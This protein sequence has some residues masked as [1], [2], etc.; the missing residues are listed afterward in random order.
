MN[1]RIERSNL[2]CMDPH[3]GRRLTLPEI[4]AMRL[5]AVA[6]IA[7]ENYRRENEYIAKVIALAIV[8]TTILGGAIWLLNR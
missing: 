5:Q 7:R 6:D 8:G 3:Y 4:E 2:I 1:S